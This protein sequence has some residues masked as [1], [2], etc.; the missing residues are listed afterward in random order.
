MTIDTNA[1]LP[2]ATASVVI[3]LG[4]VL[5]L[6]TSRRFKRE[7]DEVNAEIESR[8]ARGEA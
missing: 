6:L 5:F 4:M 3:V 8:I 1:I 7:W 2:W